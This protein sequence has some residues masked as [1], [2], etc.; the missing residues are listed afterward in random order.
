[1]SNPFVIVG[2]GLAAGK[3]VE[4]LRESG[5]DGQVIVYGDEQHLPYERPPLS[6]GY[7]L[8]NDDI[9]TAF[10]HSPDWYD[11]HDIDL[12]LG[13]SVTAIDLGAHHVV[14]GSETQTYDKLL[15]ATGS[16]PRHLPMADDSGSSPRSGPASGSRSSAPAGSGSR[17]PRRHA[18]RAVR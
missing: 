17:S 11:E 7:L 4:A 8:G 15:I 16:S 5:H 14:A 2:A 9:E 10:V 6:K 18:T 13:S 1:M 12:R 3:A